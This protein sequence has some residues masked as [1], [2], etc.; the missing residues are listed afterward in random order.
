M[1]CTVT[2][3]VIRSEVG[4]VAIIITPVHIRERLNL[5]G[6]DNDPVM[7][8]GHLNRGCFLRAKYDGDI[9]VTTLHKGNLSPQF[10]YLAHVLIQC[11]GPRNF[12]CPSA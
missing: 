6:N 1:D 11:L 5:G 7:F 9:S 10:K 8:D 12:Y 4:E 3:S 2:P